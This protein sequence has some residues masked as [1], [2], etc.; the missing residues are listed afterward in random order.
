MSDYDP[1]GGYG[2]GSRYGPPQPSDYGSGP[3]IPEQQ[4]PYP[5]GQA[6]GRSGC[7]KWAP[8]CLIAIAVVIAILAGLGWYGWSKVK[9]EVLSEKPISVEKTEVS[10]GFRNEIESV[11]K[12]LG[13][14]NEEEFTLKM[15]GPEFSYFIL[16]IM[17][18]SYNRSG[19]WD[20]P[21]PEEIDNINARLK[22]VVKDGNLLDF[23]LS[24]PIIS[25][26]YFFN[27]AGLGEIEITDGQLKM[28]LDRIT[29]GKEQFEGVQA[30]E[31]GNKLRYHLSATPE[32]R[33]LL[34]MV[35]ELKVNNGNIYMK[36]RA[37]PYNPGQTYQR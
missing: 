28:N 18:N 9:K 34:K 8:G 26:K 1:Y 33:Y 21:E 4:G 14:K 13:E 32:V 2:D 12:A 19:E 16:S 23:G 31:F 30:D 11:L 3:Y 5:P 10:R 24:F 36:V 22:A 35:P 20:V 37:V 17:H 25:D 27:V 15:T 6:Q 29:I 7:S